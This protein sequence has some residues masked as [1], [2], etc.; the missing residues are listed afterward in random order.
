MT[1][2]ISI[3]IPAYKHP[4]F[5]ERLLESILIQ[6]F[7]DYEVICSDDTAG[8]ELLELVE[9]YEDKLSIQYL[10]N[11]PAL[12]SPS[13]WNQAISL[14]KGKWIKLMHGD[15][16]FASKDALL[17]FAN[18]AKKDT[19]NFI[20]SGYNLVEDDTILKTKITSNKNIARL[21]NNPLWL[22]KENYVGSPSTILVKNNRTEWYDSN[23]KWVVDF[24][25]YYWLLKEGSF[26]NIDEALIN[27]GYGSHQITSQ[28]F[29]Q[30]AV[31]IPENIY[32]LNK[33]GVEQLNDIVVYDYY[34]R[35][36]RNLNIRKL[37]EVV[38]HLNG[39]YLPQRITKL[40]N[41]QLK[42]KLSWL[43]IGVFSKFFM[44]ISYLTNK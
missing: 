2:L 14:A 36:F 11:S 13:N 40:L 15:D 20:F 28:V 18:A 30:R 25:F 34:W 38:T 23:L 26:I 12:G 6:T 21:K 17:A 16:W 32:M 27:I 3:C 33:I 44:F 29:R 7:T 43:K 19:S 1:P 9:K 41:F 31:E 5:L 10:H 35:I 39:N 22:F 24:E 8:D 4:A 37:E 42:L